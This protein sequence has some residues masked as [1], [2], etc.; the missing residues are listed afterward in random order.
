MN[1]QQQIDS[2]LLQAHRLALTHLRAEPRRLDDAVAM[3]ARWRE[4]AGPTRSDPYWD[5][6]SDLLRAGVEAIEREACGTD[7]HA[8]ALRSVSPLSVLITQQ[9]RAALLSRAR[10]IG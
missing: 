3:L 2:F 9:E 1:R 4:Q 10:H 8:A 6:W 7:D 5:E